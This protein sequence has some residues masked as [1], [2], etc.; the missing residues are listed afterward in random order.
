VAFDSSILRRRGAPD[1]FSDEARFPTLVQDQQNDLSAGLDALRARNIFGKN[2]VEGRFDPLDHGSIF[3]R[4]FGGLADSLRDTQERLNPANSYYNGAN[5]LQ[6][7]DISQGTADLVAG[8]SAIDRYAADTAQYHVNP[9]R[10]RRSASLD[11]S[12]T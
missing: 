7:R 9:L 8:P 6:R 1:P 10:R 3:S 4:Q 11:F 5:G 2:S 12:V